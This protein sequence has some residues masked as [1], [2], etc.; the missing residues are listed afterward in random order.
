MRM[1]SLLFSLALVFAFHSSHA[2]AD[3][4]KRAYTKIIVIHAIGGPSCK[5]DGTLFSKVGGNAES[6]KLYF[7]K[8]PTLSIHYIVDREG[9][10]AADVPD[11]EIANHALGNNSHSIGIELVNDGDGKDPYPAAQLDALAKLVSGLLTRYYLTPADL[12]T[13]E[14]IDT[15][16]FTCHGQKIKTKQDPG[17]LFDMAVFRGRLSKASAAATVP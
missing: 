5:A 12:R 4:P 15:R 9:G 2:K 14:E 17:P 8:D 7:A 13:H 1:R 16:T 6:W 3:G 11:D 10:V